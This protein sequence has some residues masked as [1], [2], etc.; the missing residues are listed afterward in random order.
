[1]LPGTLAN[2][3]AIDE[4]QIPL[5]PL[6]KKAAA[7]LILDECIG[8]DVDARVLHFANHDPVAFD[9]L[10]IGIG[11]MPAG[12]DQHESP[13]LV[14]VKP[15]QTFIER[16]SRRVVQSR[17]ADGRDTDD[18]IPKIVVVGGGVAGVEIAFCVHTRMKQLF[19]KRSVSIEIVT[20][21][22][23][24]ADGMSSRSIQQLRRLL[25]R[26]SINV[27]TDFRVDEVTEDEVIDEDGNGR[28][29]DVVLWATGAAAPPLLGSLNLPTDDRGFLLTDNTLRTTT[30]APIFAVGDSGTIES[31]HT[32]KAGVFAVRQAPVLWQNLVATL[33]RTTLSRYTPQNE[34]LRI[35]NTGDDKALLQYKGY[36]FHAGWCW[37]LKRWIDKRFIQ[38]YQV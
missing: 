14:P 23:Q 22:E 9:A 15:M 11:S 7:E 17:E 31:E 30:G 28:R 19:P 2:Q 34:F 38:Q 25:S 4:M 5:G 26:R 24:I 35:L 18:R 36:S 1:M 16:L 27:T 13:S 29:A 10:S 6:A 8:L 20:S 3:F 33:N 12:W 21:G 32:P 37:Q